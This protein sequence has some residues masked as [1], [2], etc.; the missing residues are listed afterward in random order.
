MHPLHPELTRAM[1]EMLDDLNDMLCGS[2]LDD[3]AVKMHLAGSLRTRA[4]ESLDYYVGDTAWI[5]QNLDDACALL[6]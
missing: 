5:K 6:P 2:R 4:T 1:S 3:G